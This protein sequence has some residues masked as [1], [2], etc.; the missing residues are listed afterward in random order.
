MKRDKKITQFAKKLVQLSKDAQGVVTEAQ[1]GQ[2]LAA[3]K[4]A[5]MRG[6]LSILKTYLSY[7]RRE[8]AL[9]TA[10]V[11]TPGSLSQESLDAISTKFTALYGRTVT[12]QVKA[13]PSLIAG[14][15]VR[16]GDDVYDASIA[17]RLQRLAENVH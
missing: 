1:V 4:Q 13:D 3:I 14:L 12:A 5:E 8:V 2:V 11:S 17:G 10:L 7:L 9:Q 6:H 16:V 15:R